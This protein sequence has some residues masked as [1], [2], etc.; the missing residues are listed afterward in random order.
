M[1]T[2]KPLRTPDQLADPRDDHAATVIALQA[3]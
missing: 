2:F 1:N 3:T